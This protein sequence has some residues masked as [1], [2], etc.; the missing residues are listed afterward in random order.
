[1]VKAPNLMLD[2]K[3]ASAILRIDNFL[4]PKLMIPN[5]LRNQAATFQKPIGPGKIHHINRYMVS[6]IVG[7]PFGFSK[8]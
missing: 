6:V 8:D 2:T 7:P 5:L 1:M 4:K 3:Q